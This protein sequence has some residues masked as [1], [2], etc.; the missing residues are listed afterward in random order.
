MMHDLGFD[1]RAESS[2]IS[3]SKP[4]FGFIPIQHE[5]MLIRSTD[6]MMLLPPPPTH[7][8]PRLYSSICT[9]IQVLPLIYLNAP[10]TK[11]FRLVP[12]G[13]VEPP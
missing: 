12:G 10:G 2:H 9:A 8:G 13:G 1:D 11:Q 5:S 7:I 3:P 4:L 6:S